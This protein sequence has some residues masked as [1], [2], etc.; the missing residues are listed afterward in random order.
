M[1]INE[2]NPVKVTDQI[3]STIVY[4]GETTKWFTIA[5]INCKNASSIHP[6]SRA[7]NTY[8]KLSTLGSKVIIGLN[9]L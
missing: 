6:T 3:V 4:D 5:Q 7:N 8:M 1:V 2:I 9:K